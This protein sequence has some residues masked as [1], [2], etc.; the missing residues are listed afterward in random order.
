MH[1]GKADTECLEEGSGESAA[2][3]ELTDFIIKKCVTTRLVQ[4]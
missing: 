3:I 1:Q 2:Y 4:K